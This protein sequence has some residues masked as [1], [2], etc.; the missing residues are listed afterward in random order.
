MRMAED[1]PD[2][3]KWRKAND[4][5]ADAEEALRQGKATQAEVDKAQEEY[6]HVCREIDFEALAGHAK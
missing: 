6:D 3:P 4:K 5:L 1:H 2:Y